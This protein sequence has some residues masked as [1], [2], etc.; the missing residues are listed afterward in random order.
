MKRANII[1]TTPKYGAGM[2]DVHLA[3]QSGEMRLGRKGFEV[4][5]KSIICASTSDAPAAMKP[6]LDLPALLGY[7]APHYKISPDPMDYVLV[8]VPIILTDTPNRNGV[9]F[10]GKELAEFS[11]DHGMPY[12]KTWIG[13]PTH[14][15]HQNKDITKAKGIIVDVTMNPVKNRPGYY[16]VMHL[17]AF[18]R[19]KDRVLYDSLCNREYNAYSMGAYPGRNRCSLCKT[20]WDPTGWPTCGHIDKNRVNF[21]AVGDQLVYKDVL[22]VTGFECSLV[23]SPA[24]RAA[25]SDFINILDPEERQHFMLKEQN[26]MG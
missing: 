10:P 3:L 14:Y 21:Y 13:K 5:D 20:E 8:P 11:P 18:D 24:W 25:H 19:T 7:A 4:H 12:F 9:S 1:K 23:K 2:V 16:K 17:L 15:E 26:R 6:V 22:Y